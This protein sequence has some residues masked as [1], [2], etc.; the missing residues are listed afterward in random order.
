[1]ASSSPLIQRAK[2]LIRATTLTFA[3]IGRLAGIDDPYYFSKLFRRI[4]GITPT[5]YAA[6]FPRGTCQAP[7]AEDPCR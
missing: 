5:E 2:D 6:W 1:M 3:E 7:E 4:E